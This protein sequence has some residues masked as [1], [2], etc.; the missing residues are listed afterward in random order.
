[1]DG[2]ELIIRVDYEFVA[3][4]RFMAINSR[5]YTKIVC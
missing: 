5:N 3:R 2:H 1:M 4:A